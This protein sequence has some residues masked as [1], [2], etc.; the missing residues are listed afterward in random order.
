MILKRFKVLLHTLSA[1]NSLLVR[2]KPYSSDLTGCLR[3]RRK[4]GRDYVYL[5]I[6][7]APCPTCRKNP[8][9]K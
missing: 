6:D 3:T 5:S 8:I 4:H 2:Y 1:C 7:S 9:K